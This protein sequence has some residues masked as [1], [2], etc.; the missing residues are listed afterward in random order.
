MLEH[1]CNLSLRSFT[2][3]IFQTNTIAE[4][5]DVQHPISFSLQT[6]C[7]NIP[8]G[9]IKILQIKLWRKSLGYVG[10]T[11]I[12]CV[13]YMAKDVCYNIQWTIFRVFTF[14]RCSRLKIALLTTNTWVPVAPDK[15]ILSSLPCFYSDEVQQNKI[16]D[17]DVLQHL[18]GC[19][20]NDFLCLSMQGQEA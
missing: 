4:P 5:T 3:L 7:H 14:K 17:S 9:F 11:R 15:N 1:V 18:L 13:N 10:T 19:A 16:T 2:Y 12:I 6:W 20:V 8:S